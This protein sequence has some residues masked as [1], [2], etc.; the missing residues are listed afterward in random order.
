M[1]AVTPEGA[2][3]CSTAEQ[4]YELVH[5]IIE[6]HARSG[7]SYAVLGAIGIPSVCMSPQY[8]ASCQYHHL[9]AASVLDA[10]TDSTGET[11]RETQIAP[12]QQDG[13]GGAVLN[14]SELFHLLA[15]S[16]GCD[17]PT[18]DATLAALQQGRCATVDLVALTE[19]LRARG[20]KR[21]RETDSDDAAVAQSAP[22]ETPRDIVV[23]LQEPQLHHQD[24][25]PQNIQIKAAAAPNEGSAGS[26]CTSFDD[27]PAATAKQSASPRKLRAAFTSEEDE[28]ILE[29]VAKYTGADRFA[30][31]FAAYRDVWLPGRSAL[32]IAYHWRA[33]LR[34]RLLSKSKK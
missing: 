26:K 30:A 32:H 4:K 10:L 11:Q 6:K 25:P 34:D 28:A 2:K 18:L 14:A 22:L 9:I 21:M 13:S 19:A 27:V 24:A 33:V 31:I 3:L 23:A 1:S 29:G 7:N 20:P 12:T 17:A 5:A 16:S 15:P 8:W